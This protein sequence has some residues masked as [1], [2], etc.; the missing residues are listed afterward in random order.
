MNYYE[1]LIRKNNNDN[2]E[3]NILTTTITADND[4][5]ARLEGKFW[6]KKMKG[7]LIKITSYPVPYKTKDKKVNNLTEK[8]FFG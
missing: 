4:I 7:E 8:L 6:A 3:T 2:K 5:S 1:I